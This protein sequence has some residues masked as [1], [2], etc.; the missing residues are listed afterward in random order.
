MSYVEV[1]DLTLTDKISEHLVNE[2][3]GY[4]VQK[5]HKRQR[6]RY[7]PITIDEKAYYVEFQVK[8]WH[9]CRSNTVSEYLHITF[10]A[11][12]L[13]S[14][15]FDGINSNNIESVYRKLMGYGVVRFDY[16]KF[17]NLSEATNIE[18]CRN[19]R[20]NKFEDYL[21][22]LERRLKQD[23]KLNP[24]PNIKNGKKEQT[25]RFTKRENETPS[26]PFLIIYNKELE[27]LTKSQSFMSHYLLDHDI[28]DLRRIE[29]RIKDLSHARAIGLMDTSLKTLLGL[30]QNEKEDMLSRFVSCYLSKPK[31]FDKTALTRGKLVYLDALVALIGQ[32]FC[33]SS[34]CEMLLKSQPNRQAKSDKRK[35]LMEIYENHIIEVLNTINSDEEQG[36]FRLLTITKDNSLIDS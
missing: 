25:L 21:A 23:I 35:E 20:L 18:F 19:F 29:F 17:L 5:K 10:N 26:K 4:M 3:T 34:A 2:N 14:D 1:L 9:N 28:T 13:E 27:L 15:Y 30:N 16:D 32:G 11:K 12:I 33:F 22:Q 31:I 7:Y 24:K 36:I 6:S 8:M